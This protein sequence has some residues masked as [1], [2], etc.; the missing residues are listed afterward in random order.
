MTIRFED[1]SEIAEAFIKAGYHKT[2]E[3]FLNPFNFCALG[4]A[5]SVGEAYIKKWTLE[6]K[7]KQVH[8][9]IVSIGISPLGY[10]RVDMFPISIG[11]SYIQSSWKA[12]SQASKEAT[13]RKYWLGTRTSY[14]ISPKGL[15]LM[16]VEKIERKT[17]TIDEVDIASQM[18][19]DVH[20][21]RIG[22]Y[23]NHHEHKE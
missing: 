20:A 5:Y 16:N 7:N 23:K 11:G 10:V 4:P 6:M 13:D 3:K 8:R 21:K 1:P 22:L 19:I 2:D 18:D 9:L 17:R 12:A 15:T 14:Y